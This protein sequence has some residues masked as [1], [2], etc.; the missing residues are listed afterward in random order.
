MASHGPYRGVPHSKP[1][2]APAVTAMLSQGQL[3]PM[4]VLIVRKEMEDMESVAVLICDKLAAESVQSGVEHIQTYAAVCHAVGQLQRSLLHTIDILCQ[5]PTAS[6]A[7]GC[8]SSVR[9]IICH[10]QNIYVTPLAPIGQ[11]QSLQAP[12]H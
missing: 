7:A 11:A 6:T 2:P 5:K 10:N 9:H 12:W 3:Q 4:E 1:H 8:Q